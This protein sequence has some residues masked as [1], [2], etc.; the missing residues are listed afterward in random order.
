MFSQTEFT[1]QPNMV[2][3]HLNESSIGEVEKY[4]VVATPYPGGS[5][6]MGAFATGPVRIATGELVCFSFGLPHTAPIQTH[7]PHERC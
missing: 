3:S 4:H 7:A 2:S 1:T 6:V 5:E